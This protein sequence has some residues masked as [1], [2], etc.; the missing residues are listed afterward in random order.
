MLSRLRVRP[1]FQPRGTSLSRSKRVAFIHMLV[2][3]ALATSWAVVS[4]A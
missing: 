3:T 4:A 1:T 2:P